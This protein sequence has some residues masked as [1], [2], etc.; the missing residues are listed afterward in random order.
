MDKRIKKAAGIGLAVLAVAVAGGGYYNFHV[1]NDTPAYTIEKVSQSIEEHDIREFNHAV[2]LDS[3]L[4]SGYDGFVAGITSSE[5]L[6]NNDAADTL[7]NFTNI[8]RAP[9]ILS[10][11]TAIE[12]YVETGNLDP[13]ENSSVI[14]LLERTGLNDVEVRNVKNIEIN[15]ADRNEAFADVIIFQPELDREFPLHILLT[16]TNDNQWQVTGVQ[17]FQEYVTQIAK[18]RRMQL[19]DYLAEASEINAKHDTI[20]REAEDKY[21]SILALGNLSNDKT[22]NDLKA[23]IDDVMKKD[24]EQRKEEL[25]KLHVP[26]DAEALHNLYMRI[27]DTAID[28]AQDYSKWLDDKNSMSIKSAE[29]KIHQVQS[30]MND[31]GVLAGRMTS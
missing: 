26:K 2:N 25:F 8:L 29:D 27:C 6:K 16:R 15:D 22:R 31:A 30:M 11:K 4:N 14:D 20:L 28:A 21:G 18:A 9:L 3:V 13:K 10:L 24:W 19:D 7:K 12:T 5:I 23:L 1:A 17:N